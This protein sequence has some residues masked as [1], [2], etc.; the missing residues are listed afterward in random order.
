MSQKART[1][2]RKKPEGTEL[3]DSSESSHARKLA[4]A[5]SKEEL[6]SVAEKLAQ[7]K[8]SVRNW[9]FKEA[10]QT[11]PHHPDMRFVDRYFPY[12]QGGP[13]LVDEPSDEASTKRCEQKQKT[14][15]ALG[16]RHVVIG[17][18]TKLEQAIKQLSEI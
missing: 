5:E 13:L 10:V 4:L 6:K 2:I 12:A 11:Y 8:V 7:S 15:K 1:I 18:D 9:K 3:P 14:L 17:R 16:Y